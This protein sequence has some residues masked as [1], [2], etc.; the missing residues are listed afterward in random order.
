MAFRAESEAAR[1]GPAVRIFALC[2]LAVLLAAGLCGCGPF[3]ER[4]YREDLV[5][6]LEEGPDAVVIK[7]WSFLLGS[8]ADVYYR[9]GE[10]DPVLLGTTSGA[11]DGF[12]P[13]ENGLY[14]ITKEGNTVRVSWCFDPGHGEDRSFWRSKTFDI[15]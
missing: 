15:P 14:E 2:F 9:K 1:P 6:P 13:F 4:E 11:D 8:G 3:P 12:C 5:V 10:E 7:E